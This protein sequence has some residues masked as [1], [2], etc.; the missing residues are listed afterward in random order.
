[1]SNCCAIDSTT[2]VL[3]DVK[4]CLTKYDDRGSNSKITGFNERLKNVI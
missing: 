4:F 2:V 3:L 1:M